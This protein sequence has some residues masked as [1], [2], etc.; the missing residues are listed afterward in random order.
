MRSPR[1]CVRF[2]A[3]SLCIERARRHATED[4]PAGSEAAAILRCRAARSATPTWT[5]DG[6]ALTDVGHRRSP[7]VSARGNEAGSR[8]DAHDDRGGVR[9]AGEGAQNR[10]GT[11]TRGAPRSECARTALHA[12]QSRLARFSRSR[13]PQSAVRDLRARLLLAQTHQLPENY[14]SQD[15]SSLLGS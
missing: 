13:Q 12:R 3:S 4:D 7:S 15:E 14:Y 11:G 9:P 1:N 2:S 10:H 5:A 6:F 8:G